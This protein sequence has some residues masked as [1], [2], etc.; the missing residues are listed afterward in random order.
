M[1]SLVMLSHPR[2]NFISVW[3][4]HAFFMR[5]VQDGLPTYRVGC[6]W[7][8]VA[9]ILPVAKP[10]PAKGACGRSAPL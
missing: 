9:V 2:L 8:L 5:E 3:V 10:M 4:I 1:T 7:Q 6:H